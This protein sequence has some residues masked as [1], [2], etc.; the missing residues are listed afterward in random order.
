MCIL[1]RFIYAQRM[2]L[3]RYIN[4]FPFNITSVYGSACFLLIYWDEKLIY[5]DIIKYF[6]GFVIKKKIFLAALLK[7][8]IQLLILT[9][10]KLYKQYS[11][12]EFHTLHECNIC[13]KA[14]YRY[15]YKLSEK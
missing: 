1:Q 9:F 4:N 2:P 8:D 5:L 6:K 13:F 3:N 10:K 14:L 12:N 7:G 15:R 11:S